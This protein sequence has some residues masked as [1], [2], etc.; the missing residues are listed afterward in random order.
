[1]L[2]VVQSFLI[3][4]WE[5]Q[6]NLTLPSM[7]GTSLHDKTHWYANHN[8][9]LDT[10]PLLAMHI[11]NSIARYTAAPLTLVIQVNLNMY[12]MPLMQKSIIP[13]VM[14]ISNKVMSDIAINSY[15]PSFGTLVPSDD[16]SGTMAIKSTWIR[17]SSYFMNSIGLECLLI[18][19]IQ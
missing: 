18:L 9:S 2:L 10:L 19:W 11:F 8:S 17:T 3:I 14:M 7:F 15:K 4:S 1:M 12:I 6:F 5:C 16:L 13:V